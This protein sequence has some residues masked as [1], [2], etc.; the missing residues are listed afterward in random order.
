MSTIQ[1]AKAL[2]HLRKPVAP[3]LRRD[4]RPRP[5]ST[6]EPPVRSNASFGDSQA[7]TPCLG[8]KKSAHA[9]RS[10]RAKPNHRSVMNPRTRARPRA[11]C[12]KA[13]QSHAA[14]VRR[15]RVGERRGRPCVTLLGTPT[16][17]EGIPPVTLSPFTKRGMYTSG[18]SRAFRGNVGAM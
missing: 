15:Q 18:V 8:G 3:A 5:A 1:S 17:S 14:A 13:S 2:P 7:T 9:T 10:Q 16:T 4:G 6:T 12:V 11:D